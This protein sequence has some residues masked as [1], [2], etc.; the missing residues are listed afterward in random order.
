MRAAALAVAILV[1]CASPPAPTKP[2]PPQT[3]VLWVWDRADDLRFLKPGEA[4]VAALM[5]TIYLRNGQADPWHRK[6]P[7][8]LPKGIEPTPVVRLESDGS[9][10]P[11][12]ESVADMMPYRTPFQIDFDV[13]QS[14]LPW[15]RELLALVDKRQ[16][17]LSITS[18]MSACLDDPPLTAVARETVPML[19]RMG[20][21]RNAY[22]AKLQ[23]RGQFA[24]GCRDSL[25]LATDEPL[26]WRPAAKRIYVFNPNR[27]SRESFDQIRS[28][29]R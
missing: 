9:P 4:E 5:Q 18:V 22:L 3:I 10:L 8:L 16:V 17:P 20:P 13:R 26:P 27:W 2:P 29:L 19:F 21:Q 23:A 24:Q 14:Q 15:Y 7:L 28:R 1:S 11:P 6:L 25:G 12:P